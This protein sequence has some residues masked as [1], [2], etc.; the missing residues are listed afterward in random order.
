MRGSTKRLAGNLLIFF[1]T[2]AISLLACELFVRQSGMMN[3]VEDPWDKGSSHWYEV[4]LN[5]EGF[6]DYEHN[7]G[8]MDGVFR[9][10]VLGDSFTW[11]QGVEA[12]K[13][14]PRVLQKKLNET[15]SS[16]R[17]E[18]INAAKRGWNTREELNYFKR[19]GVKYEPDLLL[20]GFVL[21][22]PEPF[23]WRLRWKDSWEPHPAARWLSQ[24]SQLFHFLLIEYYFF[25][26]QYLDTE[27]SYARYM[28]QV[29][30][31]DSASWQDFRAAAKELCDVARENNVQIV[32]VLFPNMISLND[33]YPFQKWHAMAQQ[34]WVANGAKVLDLFPVFKGTRPRTLHVSVADQH[35]NARA[36]AIAAEAI[37]QYLVSEEMVPLDGLG[38]PLPAMDNPIEANFGNEVKLLGYTLSPQ[39]LVAGDTLHLV[40]YWQALARLRKDYTVFV[41]L[42]DAGGAVVAGQDSTPVKA[43]YPTSAWQPGETVVDWEY[44][45]S[46]AD[47]PPGDYVIEVGLYDHRTGIRLDVLDWAG[48]PQETR[49]LLGPIR[50]ESP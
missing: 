34:V 27:N 21:N 2:L 10:M 48:N 26:Y 19:R 5:L 18:V 47:V 11:G 13:V 35:P 22:D 33:R 31:E 36:N 20:V 49:V 23:D 32:V 46:L 25:H 28:E 43:T 16:Q 45:L 4:W 37:Y 38:V 42:L 50:V 3:H 1:L 29:W 17:F 24:K 8:K 44:A 41:H 7:V 40:L 15:I 6:R 9:I 12:D 14:Y 30:S 39:R